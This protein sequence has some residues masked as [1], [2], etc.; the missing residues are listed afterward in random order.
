[1]KITLQHGAIARI[2]RQRRA[3]RGRSFTSGPEAGLT[4]IELLMAMTLLTVGLSAI[5]GLIA[6]AMG[7]NNRNK[8]DTTAILLAQNVIELLANVPASV[9]NRTITL[10]DCAGNV[11]NISTTPGG[12][13]LESGTTNIDFSSAYT[14]DGYS[15]RYVTCG[16]AG[17]M[18][19]YDVR[20][21]I[22]HPTSG[23]TQ[24]FLKRATVAARQ[25]GGSE[26]SSALLFAM[27][28]QIKT[29]MGI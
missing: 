12:A 21:N 16:T 4:F 9:D 15:M 24:T 20:W 8:K 13:P 10:T 29:V 23:S 7:S 5:L 1:M 6:V 11:W 22:D 2:A 27:P 17:Q 26:K 19:I 14:T 25:T 3:R 18:A 28:V